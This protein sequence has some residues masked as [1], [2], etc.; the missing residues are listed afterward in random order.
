MSACYGGHFLSLR[1]ENEQCNYQLA[2]DTIANRT[3]DVDGATHRRTPQWVLP[4]AGCH[5]PPA[6][7]LLHEGH[8]QPWGA[9]RG[10][11]DNAEGVYPRASAHGEVLCQQSDKAHQGLS[12]DGNRR[13]TRGDSL[14]ILDK[15][16]KRTK[17]LCNLCTYYL[18]KKTKDYVL[19]YLLSK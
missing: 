15:K 16:N 8:N 9:D 19:M 3:V 10:H 13:H 18:N 14:R 7:A 12:G 6:E 5:P 11:S 17:K 1:Y 2:A 4:A